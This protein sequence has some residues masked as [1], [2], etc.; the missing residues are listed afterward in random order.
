ML[1]K[2]LDFLTLCD[3]TPL[4]AGRVIFPYQNDNKGLA[5]ATTAPMSCLCYARAGAIMAATPTTTPGKPMNALEAGLSP[6]SAT[7]M[8]TPTGTRR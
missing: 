2:S 6:R 5:H 3:T 7:P 4:A 8:P 1:L